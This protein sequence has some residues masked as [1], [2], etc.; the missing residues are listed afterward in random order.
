MI[1]TPDTTDT[2]AALE[3]IN[4][5]RAEHGK[6]AL[7]AREHTAVSAAIINAYAKAVR[8]NKESKS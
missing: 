2:A 7:E 8:R 1:L 3:Y 4:S 5:I 6:P